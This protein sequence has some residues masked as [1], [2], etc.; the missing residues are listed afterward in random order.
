VL[1]QSAAY[2]KD[3]EGFAAKGAPAWQRRPSALI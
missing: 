3:V 2:V 1:T